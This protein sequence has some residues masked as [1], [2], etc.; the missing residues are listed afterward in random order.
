MVTVIAVVLILLLAAYFTPQGLFSATMNFAAAV[1]ASILAFGL[2]EP[3]ARM[4][5]SFRPEYSRGVAF[6]FVFMV[7]FGILRVLS[8]ILVPGKITLP[9]WVDWTGGGIMGFFAALTLVGSLIV[10]LE[11]LPMSEMLIGTI[12]NRD[13]S[14]AVDRSFPA[15]FVTGI[16][17]LANGRSLGGDD[18]LSVHPDLSEEIPGYRHTVQP[19]G[20]QVL[21]PDLLQVKN[22][23][24]TK[25]IKLRDNKFREA[26]SDHRFVVVRTV[27]AKG[28]TPPKVSVD[29]TSLGDF[30]MLTPPQ[31]RL[32]TSGA[33]PVYQ[34]FP[35]GDLRPDGLEELS[36]YSGFV[37]ED[38]DKTNNAVQ[39][40]VFE[41]PESQTP[42]LIEIKRGA[43]KSLDGLK[44]ATPLALLTTAEATPR[45]YDKDAAMVSVTVT[46]NGQPVN[47]AEVL[48]LK[49]STPKR[50]VRDLIDNTYNLI[51]HSH[52]DQENQFLSFK[53]ASLETPQGWA[54]MLRPMFNAVK[55]SAT[56]D[57][58]LALTKFVQSDLK[59]AIDN[60][61]SLMKSNMATNDR[62]Q[63]ESIKLPSDTYVVLVIRK[64]TSS[65]VAKIDTLT[66]K[67]ASPI[68]MPIDLKDAMVD[69]D[70]K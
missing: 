9:K 51:D 18:L 68:Q 7:A 59:P 45:A 60:A 23:Y 52:M 4:M 22:W 40:W 32:V 27:I 44:A 42:S 33:G 46:T 8:D 43:R 30:L 2:L 12:R 36:T 55:N 31:V 6:L 17:Y 39:D 67:S 54:D 16:Y 65:F 14:R 62:G 28:D 29:S 64:T 48:I 66:V 50:P 37:R 34:Y 19:D 49:S 5:D 11:Y 21:D 15:S 70:R 58:V 10:G 61:H 63:C 13:E 35:I 53:N 1:F 20:R 47:G 26:S 56:G 38:F 24:V 41:L 3:L 25:T 69:T 57:K